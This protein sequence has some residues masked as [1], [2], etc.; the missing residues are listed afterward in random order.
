MEKIFLLVF[1]F[2]SRLRFPKNISVNAVITKRYGKPALRIFRSLQNSSYKVT[3]CN[4]DIHFLTLC[5]SYNIVPKFMRFKLY[6][7]SLYRKK[8]Y[9]NWQLR[10][11]TEEINDNKQRLKKLK[12]KQL[13]CE[14]QFNEVFVSIIDS[15]FL[16]NYIC[17][18]NS[19]TQESAKNKQK[20]KLIRLG[21]TNDLLPLDNTVFNF[22]KKTLSKQ[23]QYLLSLG[24]DFKLPSFKL[25]YINFFTSFEKLADVLKNQANYTS[26]SFEDIST[27]IKSL[28]HK[29][30][31]KFNPKK[32]FN[33][34]INK[35][36]IKTLINL[37]KD[38]SIIISRPDKG[39][40]TVLLDKS[41]YIEK[42]N[43][44]LSDSSKFIL[45]NEDIF[46][47]NI[48]LED[49][50]NNLITNF[51]KNDIILPDSCHASGSHP[52]CLYGLPKIHKQDVPLRPVLSAYSTAN[53]Q[54]AKY[55]VKLLEPITY[56]DFSTKNSFEFINNFKQSN[57]SDSS[58][59]V[60]FDVA[61]LFTSIPV[62]ETI[63]II[64]SKLFPSTDSKVAN[65]NK[66]QFEKLLNVATDST[67]FLFNNKIY[68]QIDGMAMGSPLG[69]VFANIFM[70]SLEEKYLSQCPIEIK[71][72]YYKR[73]VDDTFTVF[74]NIH[75][76]EEFLNYIN[77]FHTNIKFTIDIERDRK[78]PFLDVLVNKED[79]IKFTVFRKKTFTGLSINFF[80]FCP[81]LFK[82]NAFKTLLHRSYNICSD[83][84]LIHNEID[85]L[86]KLFVNNSFPLKLL[87]SITRK[88]LQKHIDPPVPITTVPKKL[89]YFSL[90]YF[91]HKSDL[92]KKELQS[93]LSNCYPA[94]N[95]RI[96]LSN[97][98]SIGNFFSFKDKID[99][100][101]C[102]HVVY[103]YK[104]PHC[105]SGHYVGSTSRSL[106]IR[107][108]EHRGVSYR[109]KRYIKSSFSAIRNHLESIH[110]QQ[111]L[112]KDFNIL[113]KVQDQTT[114]RI[115]ESIYIKKLKPSLNNTLSAYPLCIA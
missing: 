2:L 105:K 8:F 39:R 27:F 114:L 42:M 41:D 55:I 1:L 38:P 79:G 59:F 6:K 88:F 71:P 15:V 97:N 82:I 104:C 100:L 46:K 28:A 24:L 21:I 48:K 110:G 73:Y 75:Q 12:Q 25:D 99:S 60:S 56:N 109:T 64:L 61:S 3:K 52:G 23:E 36:D 11:L 76:A 30:Y 85:F 108:C 31:Y 33:P 98:S 54:L 92:M 113:R 16:K 102:P 66:K 83:F 81:L 18:I 22:S 91:G 57:F 68:K 45:I 32:I 115:V 107:S 50:V 77:T 44:I 65:M 95:F 13:E 34:Y 111:P 51:K 37:S 86:Q 4:L 49:S 9:L 43:S 58:I 84:H 72:K 101:L 103:Q 70:N 7:N 89:I 67:Y 5:K 74:E 90:P 106:Y 94:I 96:I 112:E 53:F 17:K 93:F 47:L 14:K 29:N 80:S 19:R 78:L 69:P 10:L 26:K 35:S 62:K 40:G 20:L 63:N 87:Q